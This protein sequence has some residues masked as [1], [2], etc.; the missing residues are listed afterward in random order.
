VP[1]GNVVLVFS[2]IGYT[3]EEVQVNN[4]TTIDLSLIQDIDSLGEVVVV[5]YNTQKRGD[6]TGAI[7]VVKPE[8]LEKV[9]AAS[10]SD[11]HF[12]SSSRM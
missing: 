6:I 4:Q 12:E 8:E 5:G 11:K 1:D 9:T 2:F 3:S 7:D 10:I